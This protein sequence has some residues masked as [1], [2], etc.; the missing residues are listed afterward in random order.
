MLRGKREGNRNLF[1]LWLHNCTLLSLHLET[2][3]LNNLCSNATEDIREDGIWRGA[4]QGRVETAAN[5]SHTSNFQKHW[6]SEEPRREASLGGRGDKSE[7]QI[8]FYWSKNWNDWI[9]AQDN[10]KNRLLGIAHLKRRVNF[11]IQKKSFK[12]RQNS[13]K[14]NGA[15]SPALCERSQ[16]F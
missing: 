15:F 6:A 14:L 9:N 1:L 7:K 2:I 13:S 5:V 3:T 11:F 8:G 10:M 16:W 4:S 12:Y